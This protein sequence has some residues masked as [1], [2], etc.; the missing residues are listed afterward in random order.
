VVYIAIICTVKILF[1]HGCVLDHRF[2]NLFVLVV[3]SSKIIL[4]RTRLNHIYLL[5]SFMNSQELGVEILS[6]FCPSKSN[7]G[8]FMSGHQVGMQSMK[9]FASEMV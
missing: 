9:I 2:E 1:V 7:H 8:A 3:K 4:D 5:S 6:L